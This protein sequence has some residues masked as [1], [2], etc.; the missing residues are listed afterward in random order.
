MNIGSVRSCS[1]HPQIIHYFSTKPS[2]SA[3]IFCEKKS[4]GLVKS[5]IDTAKFWTLRN[6][7]KTSS[8]LV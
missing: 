3:A 1:V 5:A 4:L 8:K 2:I 6:W 7:A